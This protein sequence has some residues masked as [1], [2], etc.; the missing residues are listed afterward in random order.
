MRLDIFEPKLMILL[1]SSIFFSILY[2][3]L[4]DNHFSGVNFVKETIKQEVIKQ[5]INSEIETQPK[6]VALES[7]SSIDNTNSY[8]TSSNFADYN[9]QKETDAA[10]ADATKEVSID[11]KTDDL[12][13][14]NINVSAYQR[15]F[16]RLYFSL[17][18]SCLLGYGDIYPISNT[19]KVITMVQALVTVSLIVI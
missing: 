15:M 10:I 6:N 7:M 17:N 1:L 5:K 13:A 19:A 16:D 2:M 14:D 18:T 8:V 3:F 9:K 4:D 11:V 12:D